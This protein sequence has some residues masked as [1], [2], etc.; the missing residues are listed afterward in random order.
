MQRKT[1]RPVHSELTGVTRKAV[2]LWISVSGKPR[3]AYLFTRTKKHRDKKPITRKHL[4]S[5]VKLWARW[6]RHPPDDY[7]SHSLHRTKS[8]LI[9]A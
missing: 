2:A 9:I 1:A 7:V 3:S 8:L 5:L 6:L 4:S